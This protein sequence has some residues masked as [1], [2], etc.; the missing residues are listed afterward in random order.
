MKNMLLVLLFSCICSLFGQTIDVDNLDHFT[1]IDVV[2]DSI[3]IEVSVY[4]YLYNDQFNAFQLHAF[5]D[6]TFID[7]I[8]DGISKEETNIFG[9]GRGMAASKD[10]KYE[11][12][13]LSAYGHH[14]INYKTDD[15]EDSRADL[16]SRDGSLLKI[17]WQFG[18][19]K[20]P[21]QKTVDFATLRERKNDLYLIAFFDYNQNK[22][23]DHGEYKLIQLRFR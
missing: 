14:Y 3:I 21:K 17:R 16:I 6:R 2:E 22:I 23:L 9:P 1:I 5:Y 12:L 7:K 18:E 8:F 4:D 19:V 15:R 20:V 11:N 13:F 10:N